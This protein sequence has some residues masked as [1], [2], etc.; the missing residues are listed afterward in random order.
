MGCY[1]TMDIEIPCPQCGTMVDGFQ[2]K[3]VGCCMTNGVRI[4]ELP[5]R[6]SCYTWCR[7]CGLSIEL[8][9]R[10]DLS[11]EEQK[12]KIA[13]LFNRKPVGKANISGD[14]KQ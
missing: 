10:D 14:K 7:E 8:T 6:G 13:K 5:Q 9:R 12:K 11:S 2:T 3:D 4:N 1:D